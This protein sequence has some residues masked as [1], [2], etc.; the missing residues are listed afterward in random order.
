MSCTTI[1]IGY[2]DKK[3]S[4]HVIL[5]AGNFFESRSYLYI[6]VLD[7]HCLTQRFQIFFSIDTLCPCF[8]CK[9][10]NLLFTV[11]VISHNCS[12]VHVQSPFGDHQL[13]FLSFEED[14]ETW[15]RF[16]YVGKMLANFMLAT[17]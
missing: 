8:E 11:H 12:E 9:K 16:D 17:Q 7:R 1:R 13:A 6:C 2:F 5:F 4:F 3:Y 15:M 14:F 10:K